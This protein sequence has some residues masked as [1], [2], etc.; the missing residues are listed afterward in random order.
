MLFLASKVLE[1]QVSEEAR[2]RVL[3]KLQQ[4][5]WTP[6]IRSTRLD[7]YKQ[8]L[9]GS[10]G[11]SEMERSI[12]ASSMSEDKTAYVRGDIFCFED[13]VFFLVFG[14]RQ[15]SSNEIRAGIIYESQTAGP[16]RKLDAFCQKVSEHLLE[17]RDE[18]VAV[19]NDD[20]DEQRLRAWKSWH[21]GTERGFA[22]FVVRQ[23]V[24]VLYTVVR[25]ETA[26]ERVRAAALLDN[27][28]TRSFLRNAKVAYAEG[29]AGRLLADSEGAPADFSL[30]K[31]VEAGLLRRE[32][33]VSCRETG[34][35]L[36]GLPSPDALAVITV[37]DATCSECGV[38]IANEKVEEVVA[39]THLAVALLDDAAWLVNRFHSILRNLG[40]PESEIAIEPPTGDG[41]AYMMS[42]VCGEPFLFVLRDGDLTPA[43]ARRAVDMQIETGSNHLVIVATGKIHNEGRTHLLNYASRLTRGGKEFELMIVDGTSTSETEL[44]HAFERV[45]QKVMAAQLCELDASLGFSVARL[46]KTRFEL[47]Q[48]SAADA[49]QAQLTA[50]GVNAAG[51]TTAAATTAIAVQPAPGLRKE[52]HAIP[53]IELAFP[54]ITDENEKAQAS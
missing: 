28:Y 27:A 14:D 44:K 30:N 10:A 38:R 31:L 48:K 29:Y 1:H 37:S 51:A 8:A 11:V 26:R 4:E 45:S 49:H 52:E 3:E 46:I 41:E 18:E 13:H 53:L 12:A 40:I 42:N 21:P 47:L 9:L 24:D 50:P 25:K 43:F 35:A 33:L 54:G 6:L 36:L 32:V 23:D 15:T 7:C 34:H 5:N 39:P 20:E 16:L 17:A 22:R 2:L 19:G